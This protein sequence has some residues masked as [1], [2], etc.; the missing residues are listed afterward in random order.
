MDDFQRPEQ[1]QYRIMMTEIDGCLASSLGC[2]GFLQHVPC[3]HQ[4]LKTEGAFPLLRE[5]TVHYLMNY[6]LKEKRSVAQNKTQ[7]TWQ[8]TEHD[9]LYSNR[10]TN[11]TRCMGAKTEHNISI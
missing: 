4:I 5:V 3:S 11:D 7:H 8:V 1:L 2:A 10:S 6:F 9:T